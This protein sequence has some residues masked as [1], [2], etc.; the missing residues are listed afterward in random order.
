ML[1]CLVTQSMSV[2]QKDDIRE[3][4]RSAVSGP[5]NRHSLQSSS[6]QSVALDSNN[7]FTMISA[8]IYSP[9][10]LSVSTCTAIVTLASSYS[11]HH[12][13]FFI[14]YV[15]LERSGRYM[16]ILQKIH[17][18]AYIHIWF[19]YFH[20]IQLHDRICYSDGKHKIDSHSA[21]GV[22]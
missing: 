8:S 10:S 18:S 13:V 11:W 4:R 19:S 20:S 6:V 12:N 22:S 2:Q 14:G 9:H 3:A 16:Q 17:I 7:L 1:T 21:L 15:Y 5:K